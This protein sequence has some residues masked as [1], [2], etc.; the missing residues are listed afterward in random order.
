[1]GPDLQLHYAP[2]TFEREDDA[3]SWLNAERRLLEDPEGWM[4]PKDRA[5][6]ARLALPPTLIEYATGWMH[7]RDLKPRTRALYERL[8]E[9]HIL[10]KLGAVRVDMISPTLVR[11][12]YTELGPNTPT[13][14]AHAY[15]LLKSIL[16]TAVR[17]EV[18]AKNPCV[19]DRAGQTRTKH[20][21]EPLTLEELALIIENMPDRLRLAV[22]I[23]AW[24]QLRQGEVTEL[25][26]KDVDLDTGVLHV[27]R[28]VTWI[29][30]AGPVVGTP[31]GND[32]GIR[33]VAIPPHL[34]PEFR[35]HLQEHTAPGKE[36]LLFAGRDSG[37]QLRP[38]TLY[39]WF[40]PAREAAG[41]PDTRWHDLRHLGA[42]LAAATGATL[43]D[44]MA[45]LG[46]ST[47]RASMIYQHASRD[48]DKV[49]AEALSQ[50]AT[51]TPIDRKRD[52]RRESRGA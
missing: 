46:H 32:A 35:A 9:R 2:S 6:A 36:A 20:K 19:I 31:K 27:R 47:V 41:R 13:Q 23:A 39:R 51:A 7:S 15:S 11:G 21:P 45:R 14:R 25:R 24:C 10:P 49:I 34:L 3:V 42:T 33:S 43:S 48:A 17:E 29:K 52:Q 1:M 22:L 16:G 44:L 30:G 40:Y 26:R 5:A 28:A 4:P 18:I 12:W 37:Q 50:M 38:S 8:L